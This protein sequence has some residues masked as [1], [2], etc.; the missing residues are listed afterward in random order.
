MYI[1][2]F[3]LDRRKTVTAL[4][5][6]LLMIWVGPVRAQNSADTAIGLLYHNYD[7]PVNAETYLIRPQERL[8]VSFAGIKLN[9]LSLALNADGKLVDPSLGV[10]SLAG[11]NLAEA[12]EMIA[13]SI[14]KAY[15]AE[16]FEISV[17]GP[18]RV[19]IAVT[20]AVKKPGVYIG[21]TSNYVSE[22]L[23][24]AGG[25]LPTASRRHIEF[26]G[27]PQLIPVDL[28]RA[29]YYG[30]WEAN[31]CLYAG[32]RL[33]VPPRA[34]QTVHVIGEV[35]S[36]REIE[37]VPGD[38][39]GAL[40]AF[41]GG[42]TADADLSAIYLSGDSTGSQTTGSRV[43]PG[44]VI[45]VPKL[46]D[47]PGKGGSI[48]IFGAVQSPGLFPVSPGLRLAELL[49]LAGGPVTTANRSRITV[50]R[51]VSG[52]TR[53]PS[54]YERFAITVGGSDS[55]SQFL[56]QTGDSVFVPHAVGFVE[57]AGR[58]RFPGLLPYAESQD[59]GYYIRLA[60]G[61][62]ADADRQDFDITD[63]ISRQTHSGGPGSRV[64]DGDL[65]TV[66]MKETSP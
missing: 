26:Q 55:A 9:A 6:I 20:G 58:V 34:E 50:F 60:G 1:R 36:P 23:E 47:N 56:L 39:L 27:G 66:R 25:L 7:R 12:R 13:P 24:L 28:D 35:I 19:A 46:S 31:P 44:A 54:E 51:R 16:A 33:H 40:I 57:V 15:T 3:N 17:S 41:A 21:Y 48:A 32:Y 65:L 63:R 5:C 22:L 45:I 53:L 64:G 30:D 18:Y 42:P 52:E 4:I 2:N 29:G 14:R 59:A 8:I 37:L 11:R 62:L 49:R 38:T 61:F 10:F 43:R